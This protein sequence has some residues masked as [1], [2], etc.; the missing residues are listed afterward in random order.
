M[1]VIELK[2]VCAPTLHAGSMISYRDLD[3]ELA[4]NVTRAV[5]G[6]TPVVNPAGDRSG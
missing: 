5:I 6:V 1:H 4:W 2:V 3:L